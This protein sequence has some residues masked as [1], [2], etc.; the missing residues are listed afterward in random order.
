M[1][2]KVVFKKTARL[3]VTA[4]LAASMTLGSFPVAVFADAAAEP[5]PK[6]ATEQEAP[7]A[8]V[9]PAEEQEAPK[10]EAAPAEGKAIEGEKAQA[11][12]VATIGGTSYTSLEEAFKAAE[13][14]DTVTLTAALADQKVTVP[15][16]TAKITVTAESGVTF[17]NSMRINA[18]NITVTGMHFELSPAR[19][20]VLQNVIVSGA[21]NVTIKGN[22]FVIAAGKPENVSQ[23]EDWQPS[24]VW[25]E[26]GANNTNV[27]GNNFTLGQV[28]NQSS[29]GVNLVGNKDKP[30]KD[31][32]ISSNTIVTGPKFGDGASGSMSFVI[33]N[34]NENTNPSAFGIQTVNLKSN[35]FN[36]GAIKAKSYFAGFSDANNVIAEANTLNNAAYGMYNTSYKGQS[37]INTWDSKNNVYNDVTLNNFRVADQNGKEYVTIGDAIA[38]SA[39]EAK[40]LTDQS[41][42]VTIPAAKTVTLDL[43]GHKLTNKVEEGETPTHTITNNGTLTVKDS[44]GGGVVDNVSHQKA[45]L[46]NAEGAKAVLDGGTFKRSQEKGVV[47]VDADGKVTSQDHGGNTYYT[48][49]N[50]GDLTINDG[51]KV[52][53]LLEGIK[54]RENE[55]AGYSSIIRNGEGNKLAKLTINGGTITGG[56]YIKNSVNAELT[57][58]GGTIKGQRAAVLNYN[59]ATITGGTFTTQ[60][61]GTPVIWNYPYSKEDVATGALTITGGTF[62]ATDKQYVLT[63]SSAGN[64]TA[65]GSITISG[66]SFDGSFNITGKPDVAI[67]GGS[68]TV[69]PDDKYLDP[70]AGLVKDPVTGEIIVKEP[71]LLLKNAKVTYDIVKGE[72]KAADAIALVG[73]AVDVNPNDYQVTADASSLEALNT[74]IKAGKTGDYELQFMAAKKGA[75]AKAADAKLIKTATVTLTSSAVEPAPEPVEKFTVTFVDNFNKTSDKVSVEKGKA[76]AKPAD[77]AFDGWKFEG[78]FTDAA[79]K[80]A[81]DF[82]A[83]VTGDMTLYAGYSKSG[84]PTETEPEETQKP[85][86][87]KSDGKALPQTGDDSALP[88]V[89]AAGAGAVAIAAG[90]VAMKRRKQE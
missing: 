86:E 40:L 87:K 42:N 49:D 52:Q 3:A 27:T 70:N 20:G 80:S 88:M 35:T 25:L 8:D 75:K 72:L 50:Q 15:Q 28:W 76:V 81:Y 59:V 18:D 22:T 77:P 30:V 2:S 32:T 58:N 10:A 14:G 23:D 39:T 66:G 21:K 53:L 54:D 48:I 9:A 29:V 5:A 65:N 67:S 33:G 17:T 64:A 83:P 13:D 63:Q 45:A 68:Y 69:A 62:T 46:S 47:S 71:E 82:S 51:T 31:T 43:N 36:G 74:A 79:A 6:S 89:A 55:I 61:N 57:V 24:S 78:W 38:A 73:A 41:A 26:S 85:V 19:K 60:D 44:V 4:G 56:K 34:G 7:K 84:V 1:D 16:G 11:T 37:D 90:A 12:A